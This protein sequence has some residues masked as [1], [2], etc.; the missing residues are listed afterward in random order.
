MLARIVALDAAAGLANL[1]ENVSILRHF[2]TVGRE[3]AYGKG[4]VPSS[5]ENSAGHR[6]LVMAMAYCQIYGQLNQTGDRIGEV[7]DEL[8]ELDIPADISFDLAAPDSVLQRVRQWQARGNIVSPSVYPNHLD[9]ECADSNWWSY[10]REHCLRLLTLLRQQ[11]AAK[12]FEQLDAIDT[13]TPG[14][15]FVSAC[16][17]SGFRFLTGFCAP[18]IIND[19]HWKITHASAPLAPYGMS[20]DDYRKPAPFGDDGLVIASMELRNPLEC[21]E[22]W[23]EGP[24]CPLNLIMGD[25]TVEI[26][27]EPVETMAAA[28]D[29]M[30]LSA[31]TGQPRFFSINLQY[32][33]GPKCF[34]LNHRMLL[35]LK[36]QQRQGRLR[37]VG[38]RDY[39][40]ILRQHGGVL[41]Q[42]TYW[43]GGC[44]GQQV[45]GRP[46]MGIE[47][48]VAENARGQWQFRKGSAGAERYFDYA[49]PWDYPAFDPLGELPRSEGYTA[50][51]KDCA[52]TCEQDVL[53][54]RFTPDAPDHARICLWD[55]LDG[56]KGPFELLQSDG[57]AQSA[58]IVPHPGGSGG[59]ILV[60]IAR[61]KEPAKLR[62]R[63]ASRG[64]NRHSRDFKGLI[65]AETV[66]IHGRPVTRLAAAVV[67]KLQFSLRCQTS[68][69]VN[70]DTICG[71]SFASGTLLGSQTLAVE[72]DGRSTQ[73]MVRLWGVTA[74]QVVIDDQEMEALGMQAAAE[75]QRI[76]STFCKTSPPPQGPMR[77]WRESE[78]PQWLIEAARAGADRE[79]ET[80]NGMVK[81]LVDGKVVC[82]R[83]MAADLPISSKG[84]VRSHRFDRVEQTGRQEI[85]PTFYDYGQTFGP[86]L[87]GWAQFVWMGLALRGLQGDRSYTLVLHLYDPEERNTRVRVEAWRSDF[88]AQ[89]REG[90]KLSLCPPQRV[91][92]GIAGRHTRQAFVSLPI[93]P[94]LLG[95]PA[96][97][98]ALWGDSEGMRYDRY[99]EKTGSLFLS[100]AWLIES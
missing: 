50:E 89:V 43:R 75:C 76:A 62:V 7:L 96:V 52:M 2:V 15:D 17:Q 85:I 34:D 100:H 42:T 37:F 63:F 4:K 61:G 38:L 74:D 71:R 67:H 20:D 23:S 16:R 30:R 44:A 25:R 97:T 86:G 65:S 32:F 57:S 5:V 19:G 68:H 99:T 58:E 22:H 93:P 98:I 66:W 54:V 13:Y 11:A 81:S 24:F 8:A 90:P 31:L 72:L 10:S 9:P 56:F 28:E 78:Y 29:W 60:D 84:R 45:G 48:I 82:A 35:W 70:Y 73:S 69:R 95:S 77:F 59:S 12:G 1:R 46:G 91:P 49:K 18:T 33:T 51:V 83:H 79:I 53:T 40:R 21:L 92:Q 26:G 36:N 41:P 80:V 87:S 3:R 88:E 14:N 27:D 39:A 6:R 64:G 55:V 94:D 47:T